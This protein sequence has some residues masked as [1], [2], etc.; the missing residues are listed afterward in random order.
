V[1]LADVYLST[2]STPTLYLKDVAFGW[3]HQ[4]TDGDP[5]PEDL[6]LENRVENDGRKDRERTGL[7]LRHV[8]NSSTRAR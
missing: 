7:E 4:E 5:R 6:L 2:S 1:G 8:A 3:L